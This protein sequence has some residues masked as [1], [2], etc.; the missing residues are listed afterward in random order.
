M[1]SQR[2]RYSLNALVQMVAF[3]GV[4]KVRTVEFARWAGAPPRNLENALLDLKRHGL[5]SSIRGA[6]GGYVFARNPAQITFADLSHLYFKR[7]QP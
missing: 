3:H 7:S 4:R 1:V 6:N 2:V 5:I